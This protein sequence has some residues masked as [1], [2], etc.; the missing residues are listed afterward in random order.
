M[1]TLQQALRDAGL[2]DTQE[3]RSS[4]VT[5]TP[6]LTHSGAPWAP[7]SLTMGRVQHTHQY[8]PGLRTVRVDSGINLA[9]NQREPQPDNSAARIREMQQGKRAELIAQITDLGIPTQMPPS[10]T[11]PT[12]FTVIPSAHKSCPDCS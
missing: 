2:I 12:C 4:S 10:G 7:A 3:C 6:N 1:S 5:H 9:P 8:G 11:C